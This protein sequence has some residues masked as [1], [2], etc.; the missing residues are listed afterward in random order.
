MRFINEFSL[1]ETLEEP[2]HPMTA[3]LLAWTIMTRRRRRLLELLSGLPED[4]SYDAGRLADILSKHEFDAPVEA[5]ERKT[6]YINLIQKDLPRLDR[7]G[8]VEYDEDRK[9]VSRGPTFD[10]ALDAR[11]AL[12]AVVRDASQPSVDMPDGGGCVEA[13][14][15]FAAARRE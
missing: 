7:N 1:E 9:T 15:S 6:I 12:G 4:E 13:W 14:G 3:S 2:H 8:V 5:G 11:E 10:L